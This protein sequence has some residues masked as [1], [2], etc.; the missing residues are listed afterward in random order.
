VV[1]VTAHRD[2]AIANNP[3]MNLAAS[4]QNCH[5]NH[6]RPKHRRRR[7]RTLFRH[8]ASEDLFRGP[9]RGG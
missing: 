3:G 2:Q 1:L 5:I 7:W 6:N 8:K 4:C 9:C